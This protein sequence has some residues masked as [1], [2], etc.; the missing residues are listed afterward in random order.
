[1]LWTWDLTWQHAW[2]VIA[3]RM[4]QF[5]L[6]SNDQKCLQSWKWPQLGG[7]K[8]HYLLVEELNSHYT[9]L[10]MGT[11]VTVHE[12]WSL[13]YIDTCRY[14]MTIVM[15]VILGKNT[16]FDLSHLS[17]LKL[18]VKLELAICVTIANLSQLFKMYVQ[19]EVSTIGPHWTLI[20]RGRGAQY[21]LHTM[22][23]TGT[24]VTVHAH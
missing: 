18:I 10:Y 24:H 8:P 5:S 12:H 11:Q 6:W 20:F 1:M 21:S 19:L 9:T 15:H 13:V 2:F 14:K 17:K 4:R 3:N 23:Y 16:W 7:I 22:F